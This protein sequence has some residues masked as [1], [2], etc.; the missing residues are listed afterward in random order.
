MLQGVQITMVKKLI[1]KKNR[2]KIVQNIS[3]VNN[4][5]IGIYANIGSQ[6]AQRSILSAH[7]SQFKPVIHITVHIYRDIRELEIL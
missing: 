1:E 5:F 7:R 3:I 4:T 6:T 2:S